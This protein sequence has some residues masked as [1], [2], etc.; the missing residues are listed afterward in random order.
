MPLTG[1]LTRVAV[2][3]P[4]THGVLPVYLKSSRRI[5]SRAPSLNQTVVFA[6]ITKPVADHGQGI[7][8]EFCG[9]GSSIQYWRFYLQSAAIQQ[10]YEGAMASSIAVRQV[11]CLPRVRAG[12]NRRI[13]CGAGILIERFYRTIPVRY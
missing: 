2:R 12:I 13:R 9:R 1:A 6:R 11:I 8:F 10:L 4:L 3:I 5:A 7:S